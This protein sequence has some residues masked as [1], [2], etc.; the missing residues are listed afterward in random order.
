MARNPGLSEGTVK[1]G[2]ANDGVETRTGL[3][4]EHVLVVQQILHPS[5]YIVNVGRRWELYALAIL[6]D[7]RVVEAGDNN[8]R[9]TPTA[10]W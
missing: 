2:H 10:D 6:V 4:G 9:C 8:Q 7:P 1:R 3:R 5:H